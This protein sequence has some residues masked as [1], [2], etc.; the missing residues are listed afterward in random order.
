[1]V[2]GQVV[3]GSGATDKLIN[4]ETVYGS[5]F[6]DVFFGSGTDDTFYGFDGADDMNGN[7]GDDTLYGGAGDDRLRGMAGADTIYGGDGD[8]NVV[9]GDD[10]DIVK[11]G[12]GDDTVYGD[13]GNDQVLGG[14]GDDVL[15]GGDGDDLIWGS[16]GRD[17]YYGGAGADSFIFEGDSALSD[18]DNIYDF[19]TAEGD[20]LNIADVLSTYGYDPLTDAITDFVQVS[21]KRNGDT[22]IYI[23][24]DGAGKFKGNDLVVNLHDVTLSMDESQLVL[25]GT[26]IVA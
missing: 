21:N 25:D 16:Y 23:D 14:D 10:D 2:T 24:A 3:D 15:Y 22:S 19:S 4:I 12:T 17:D 6:D 8:D 18:V 20:S 5:S 9:G 11:G 13:A 7:S 26:L 1:L